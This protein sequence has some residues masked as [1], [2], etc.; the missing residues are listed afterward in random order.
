M[1]LKDEHDGANQQRSGEDAEGSRKWSNDPQRAQLR[2]RM[3]ICASLPET[4][5]Y[6]IST[7]F[8]RKVRDAA[9]IDFGELWK[10]HKR[11]GN[12][13]GALASK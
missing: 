13:E 7:V 3:G 4:E 10:T 5:Q 9:I 8:R 2:R 1:S 6:E 11:Q 12:S